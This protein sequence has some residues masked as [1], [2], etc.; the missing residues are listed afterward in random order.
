MND[1]QS[2]PMKDVVSVK[3]KYDQASNALIHYSSLVW[4]VRAAGFAAVVSGL[5]GAILLKAQLFPSILIA[6][7][8]F[9]IGMLMV[10]LDWH[11]AKH[12]DA[13]LDA[14]VNIEAG[15]GPW[16]E[17]QKQVGDQTN[18]QARNILLFVF[19]IAYVAAIISVLIVVLK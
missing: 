16:S 9:T 19:I 6:I 18:N 4:K 2:I 3:E 7:A 5:S 17:I 8:G 14:A 12:W 1:M 15:V 13:A 10:W 11:Y